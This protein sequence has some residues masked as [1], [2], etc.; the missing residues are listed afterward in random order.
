MGRRGWVALVVMAAALLAGCGGDSHSSSRPPVDVSEAQVRAECMTGTF[1]A[2]EAGAQVVERR[3][4]RDWHRIEALPEAMDAERAAV[5]V[6]LRP[7]GGAKKVTLTGIKFRVSNLGV[8]PIGNVF[9]RP[10]EKRL[11]GA[12]VETDLDG[13][14]HELSASAERATLQVGF[15]L[16]HQVNPIRFPWTVSLSKPLRLYLAVQARDIYC[17][18]TADISWADGSGEGVIHIDNGGK[19]YL[20]VD[21]QGTGWYKPGPNDRWADGGSGRWIGVR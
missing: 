20:I 8:R 10:C 16:P 11:S 4:P 17:K 3:P 9:Y 2:E 21:G 1:V 12:V 5:L 19:K 14:A 18:W 6:T 15:H 13:D 7:R